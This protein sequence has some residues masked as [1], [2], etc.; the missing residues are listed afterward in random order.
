MY[1]DELRQYN[2]EPMLMFIFNLLKVNEAKPFDL[3]IW[4][5]EVYVARG[6]FIL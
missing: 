1:I 4:G 2:L 6:T 3:S 5:I